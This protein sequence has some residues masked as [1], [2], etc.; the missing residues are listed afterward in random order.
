MFVSSTKDINRRKV[1]KSDHSKHKLLIKKLNDM[2][3]PS[4]F[5]TFE[6]TERKGDFAYHY[7][8]SPLRRSQD[9]KCR[10]SKRKEKGHS[11]IE[12]VKKANNA[13]ETLK[14]MKEIDRIMFPEERR[15]SSSKLPKLKM[16]VAPTAMPLATLVRDTSAKMLMANHYDSKRTF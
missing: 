7:T 10:T 11:A 3:T 16:M 1:I 2:P 6:T 13:K 9:E 8:P 14:E 4:C 12:A 15:Y 5:E